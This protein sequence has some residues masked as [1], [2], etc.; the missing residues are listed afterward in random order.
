VSLPV[1]SINSTSLTE[2]SANRTS[3]ATLQ[4]TLSQV[5]SQDVYVSWVSL[6]SPGGSL[7]N[8]TATASSDYVAASGTVTIKADPAAAS[9]FDGRT[10]ARKTLDAL[11]SAYQ[12]YA[13]AGQGGVSEYSIGGR[14]MKFRNAKDFIDQIRYWERVVADEEVAARGHGVCGG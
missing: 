13:T 6:S 2:G 10:D 8:A 5:F 9:A 1:A 11:K 7:P 4:V 14:T 3:T 12:S